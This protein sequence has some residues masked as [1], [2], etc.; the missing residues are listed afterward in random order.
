MILRIYWDH[1]GSSPARMLLA[2]TA[3]LKQ[4]ELKAGV[5]TWLAIGADWAAGLC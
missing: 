5:L 1:L 3:V 2:G 4:L